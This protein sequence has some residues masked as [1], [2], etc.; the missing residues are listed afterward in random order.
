MT[1]WFVP[2]L[3]LLPRPWLPLTLARYQKKTAAEKAAAADA[4]LATQTAASFVYRVQPQ[5]PGLTHERIDVPFA[6]SLNRRVV[7]LAISTLD[8]LLASHTPGAIPLMPDVR[9]YEET[10]TSATGRAAKGILD[11]LA[12]VRNLV[13]LPA[14]TEPN[15]QPPFIPAPPRANA[16]PAT[17]KVSF[18]E[19]VRICINEAKGNGLTL[20]QLY[21]VI[22]SKHSC[23]RC[24]LR[25]PLIARSYFRTTP[26]ESWRSTVRQVLSAHACFYTSL[27]TAAPGSEFCAS[28]AR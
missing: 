6:L 28:R 25:Q 17:P 21:A 3:W 23:V 16:V 13:P 24:A 4:A 7:S 10:D 15:R 18:P 1:T 8:K 11:V 12:G 14:P 2:A 9:P 20:P 26:A 5:P 27:K 22:E 19:L